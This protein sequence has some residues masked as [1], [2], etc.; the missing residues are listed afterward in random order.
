[1]VSFSLF[2]ET[3]PPT[4]GMSGNAIRRNLGRTHLDNLSV[5]VREAV[6][7]S[8][9]A[10]L[11]AE[12]TIRFD[13]H[14]GSLLHGQIQALRTEVFTKLPEGHPLAA[15]LK[16]PLPMRRLVLQDRGTFGLNGPVFHEPRR[17]GTPRRFMRFMRD[18]GRS[19]SEASG[20]GTYGFGKSC[21]FTSSEVS[22]ILVHTRY[23][24]S[25]GE[26]PTGE[27]FMAASLCNPPEDESQTGRHWWGLPVEVGGMTA[28]APAEGRRAARLARILGFPPFEEDETGTSIMILKP[29]VWESDG[30]SLTADQIAETMTSWFW[31]RMLARGRGNPDPYI[32]FNVWGDN[33]SRVAVPDPCRVP[34]LLPFVEAFKAWR[35]K[36]DSDR[37]P[38]PGYRL[39]ACQTQ[40]PQ[41]RVGWVALGVQPQPVST[42]L[43]LSAIE[44]HPLADI[45]GDGEGPS[46]IQHVALMRSTWQVIKYQD[47]E[48]ASPDPQKCYG[49]V[50]VVDPD[51]EGVEE[52][53]AQS[54]PPSHD[55]WI[56]GSLTQKVQ[57]TY[58]KAH[59]RAIE[60]A[61]GD[62]FDH[63]FS[64]GRKV[65]TDA[66]PLGAL[67]RELGFLLSATRP[68]AVVHGK[69]RTSNPVESR[70]P[71]TL[72]S[73]GAGKLKQEGGERVLVLPFQ[74][75]GKVP[76]G[77]LMARAQASVMLDGGG[78]ETEPPLGSRH[79]VV[80]RWEGP[81]G[82]VIASGEKC[83]FRPGQE[84]QVRVII[85]IPADSR[86]KVV[87]STGPC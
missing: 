50:F 34:H 82:G 85:S 31:P 58:V 2:S 33:G 30:L 40:R 69:G 87:I 8:W 75:P 74:L 5:L 22:T 77:G 83:E 56:E 42:G 61:V 65:R 55:D 57:K 68:R 62:L 76:A 12:G 64:D 59:R 47:C 17:D 24:E 81:D 18:I 51:R 37:K 15:A 44:N 7:N 41:A 86:V 80:L 60:M 84:R 63:E 13:A 49:G 53:F 10:R 1:M 52:A 73:V 11:E 71:F 6:Q 16:S 23:R 29:R 4:G 20:G 26:G 45:L 46:K 32:H 25:A 35:S 48:R 70:S 79:P 39:L 14:L 28:V 21:L 66:E 19:G 36:D 72:T 38:S 27:R 54:E 3:Y 67:S 78:R 9:D 43:S